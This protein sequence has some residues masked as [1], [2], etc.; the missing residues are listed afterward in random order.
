MTK[1][2]LDDVLAHHGVKGMKWGVRRSDAQ[3]ALSRGKEALK[4]EY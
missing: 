1:Q 4:T 3:L 2:S